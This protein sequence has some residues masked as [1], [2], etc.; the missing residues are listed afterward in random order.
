MWDT[1]GKQLAL[2]PVTHEIVIGDN[3][4]MLPMAIMGDEAGFVHL[5]EVAGGHE[6]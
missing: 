2:L 4:P 6:A 3:H 1:G 5:I